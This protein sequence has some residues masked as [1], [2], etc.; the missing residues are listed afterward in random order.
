VTARKYHK[1]KVIESWIK[2]IEE[3]LE[4]IMNDEFPY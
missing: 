3:N 4:S 1:E 2:I